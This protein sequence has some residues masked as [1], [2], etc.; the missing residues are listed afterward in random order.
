MYKRLWITV[1]QTNRWAGSVFRGSV[2][3]P[4]NFKE[5]LLAPREALIKAGCAK[6]VAKECK[7]KKPVGKKCPL[8]TIALAVDEKQKAIKSSWGRGQSCWRPSRTWKP[9]VECRWHGKV[10]WK[11]NEEQDQKW[12]DNQHH[13]N[14]LEVLP[15]KYHRWEFL[16]RIRTRFF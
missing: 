10:A 6:N 7:V 16:F 4:A 14:L 11:G 9:R 1:N 15:S 13:K 5:E 2:W 3:S 8:K 12:N